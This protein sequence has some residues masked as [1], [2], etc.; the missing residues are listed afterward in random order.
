MERLH[1]V[2]HA[3]VAKLYLAQGAPD[4]IDPQCAV[5]VDAVARLPRRRKRQPDLISA[6]AR[7][8]CKAEAV[9]VRECFIE[10][11][12]SIGGEHH[13]IARA[14]FEESSRGKVLGRVRGVE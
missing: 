7:R 3:E 6:S 12:I 13:S 8:W 14:A 4:C 1:V 9:R 11:D 5:D 2:R 10:K